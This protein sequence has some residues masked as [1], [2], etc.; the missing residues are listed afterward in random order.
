MSTPLARRVVLFL[1]TLLVV[2]AQ[3]G[4]AA[5]HNDLVKAT[6]TDGS[7][8]DSLPTQGTLTFGEAL[9]PDDLEV[10][11]GDRRLP[12]TAVPGS[13]RTIRFSLA[14]VRAAKTVV[15][16][17]TL[18]DA[19]DGHRSGGTVRWHLTGAKAQA[20]AVGDAKPTVGQ[21]DPAVGQGDPTLLRWLDLGSRALGY[22][23][24]ILLVGGLLFVSLLWP[25]GAQDRRTRALL[26]TNFAVGLRAAA[27]QVGAVVWR[28]SNLPVLETLASD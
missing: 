1:V 28:S 2:L 24:M 23:A 22:L 20:D 13:S 4:P 18:V 10:R 15:V 5:A 27:G 21:G 17:W 16:T 11:V 6:P 12:V 19:H 14:G 3:A 9:S 25:T 8:L 7:S 26:S